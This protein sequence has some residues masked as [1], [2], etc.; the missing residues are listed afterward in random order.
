MRVGVLMEGICFL[1][2]EVLLRGVLFF[3]VGIVL[4][5]VDVIFGLV[6]IVVLIL[7]VCKVF[8]NVDCV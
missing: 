4:L 5:L 6:M 1:R 8:L 7:N 3:G 2:G